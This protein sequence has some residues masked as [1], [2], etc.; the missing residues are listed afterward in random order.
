M[1]SYYRGSKLTIPF[2]QIL[3]TYLVT[4]GK[5]TIY[6]SFSNTA[7]DINGNSEISKFLK[8][9]TAWLDA[10]SELKCLT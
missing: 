1:T 6:T 7:F 2:R 8:Q 10:Q 9:Y 4:A 5:L 3:A